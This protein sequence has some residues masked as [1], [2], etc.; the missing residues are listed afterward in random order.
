MKEKLLR[1]IISRIGGKPASDLLNII[2]GKESV[3]EFLIA[4]EMNATINDVRNILYKLSNYNLVSFTREKDDKKGWYTYFWTFDEEKSLKLLDNYLEKELLWLEKQLKNRRSKTYYFCETCVR[5][6]TEE[7]ALGENFSCPECG[8]IYDL[9]DTSNQVGALEKRIERI[10]KKRKDNFKEIS[11]LK[12]EESVDEKEKPKKSKKKSKG[13]SKKEKKNKSKKLFV[14]DIKGIGAKK[15]KTLEK[16]RVKTI[17][18]LLRL[19]P[20]TLAD[21]MGVSVKMA[22]KYQDRAKKMKKV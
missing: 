9:K 4:K 15:A 21:K 3:N 5:E 19:K 22:E 20:E 12:S 13:K 17:T 7:E 11:K 16:N 1:E 18:G 10:K 6:S 8:E 2:K 14:K